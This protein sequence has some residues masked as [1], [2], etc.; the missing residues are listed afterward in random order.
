MGLYHLFMASEHQGGGAYRK[1]AD[2][3]AP[4]H[5]LFYILVADL[6][7]A[8]ERC[9]QLGGKVV[10]GPIEVPGG[11]RVAQCCD[12]QGAAFALHGKKPA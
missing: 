6:D 1:P 3:P 11:D 4:P 10:N 7:A 12:P 5:W 9:R 2:M 8:I